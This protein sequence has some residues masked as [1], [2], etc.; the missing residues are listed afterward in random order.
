MTYNVQD[1][2]HLG[3]TLGGGPENAPLYSFKATDRLENW[4][5][6][7]SIKR[8]LSAKLRTHVKKV[9]DLP[10][11]LTPFRYIIKIDATNE[12]TVRQRLDQLKAMLART[13]YFC[14]HYHPEDGQDH[15]PAV[16]TMVLTNV[17]DLK[18]FD[19]VLSRFYVE[20]SLEDNST[21]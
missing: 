7:L 20:I 21:V 12:Y 1:H 6:F 5:V 16:R 19:P 2:I 10:L 18:V 8:T 17:G 13:V 4:M 9:S 14:D 11:V 3:L 15:T